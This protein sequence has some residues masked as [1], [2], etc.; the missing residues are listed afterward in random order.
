[1]RTIVMLTFLLIAGTCHASDPLESLNTFEDTLSAM[2]LSL[3]AE[4]NGPDESVADSS[5]TGSS[6][7]SL[8]GEPQGRELDSLSAE[9]IR[10]E[11]L[12]RSVLKK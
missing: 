6:A 2:A 4:A 5:G 1:M 11:I 10:T 8:K 7:E 12:G 9:P 3:H